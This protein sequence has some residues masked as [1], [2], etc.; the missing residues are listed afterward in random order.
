MKHLFLN[1]NL[2]FN[3]MRYIRNKDKFFFEFDNNSI[4]LSELHYLIE[5]VTSFKPDGELLKDFLVKL[6]AF[7]FNPADG[8][9]YSIDVNTLKISLSVGKTINDIIH[10]NIIN[11]A[12]INNN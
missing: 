7:S 5:V 6:S 2:I 12:L 4:S 11:H 9:T 1:H 10:N 8:Y 3:I